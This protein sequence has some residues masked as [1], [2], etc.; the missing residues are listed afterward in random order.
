MAVL[1]PIKSEF[2]KLMTE[3]D[4]GIANYVTNPID[5]L[6]MGK[7]NNPHAFQG[8]FFGFYGQ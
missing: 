1:T 6:I 2:H 5:L 4:E 7:K 3:N 8:S